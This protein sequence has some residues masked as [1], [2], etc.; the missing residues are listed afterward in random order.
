M[1]KSEGQIFLKA[2]FF[3]SVH[4]MLIYPIEYNRRWI[5]SSYYYRSKQV[6]TTNVVHCFDTSVLTKFDRSEEPLYPPEI[7]LELPAIVHFC[8]Q[9]HYQLTIPTNS[10]F[11]IELRNLTYDFSLRLFNLSFVQIVFCKTSLQHIVSY[12]NR[13]AEVGHICN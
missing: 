12:L 2:I 13:Y 4:L 9:M 7:I 11:K 8:N 3:F 6:L 1:N 10:D 5:V